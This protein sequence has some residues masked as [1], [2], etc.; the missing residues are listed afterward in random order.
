MTDL[1][2]LPRS[3]GAPCAW[4]GRT[5]AVA[6][7]L[8][9]LLG[10]G[11]GSKANRTPV[12]LR[13]EAIRPLPPEPPEGTLTDMA[14]PAPAERFLRPTA[15]LTPTR[16]DSL[17][18]AARPPA[19]TAEKRPIP[20]P[21]RVDSVRADSVRT[22]TRAPDS[23]AVSRPTTRALPA[24]GD[25]LGFD[26]PPQV[27]ERVPPTLPDRANQPRVGGRVVV[28]AL[29]SEAGR[30]IDARVIRSI[31]ELDAAALECVR[32]WRFKPALDRNVPVAAWTNVP[33]V[34]LLQ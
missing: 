12:D 30:V 16:V 15:P 2:R 20:P 34:F 19:A 26:V 6:M 22:A 24:F 31:P 8:L 1:L 9:A 23:T 14:G 7:S 29:V 4:G 17:A 21:M 5:I 33:V 11:G 32:K 18:K 25:T 27:V 3:N 10:C 28:R 13:G